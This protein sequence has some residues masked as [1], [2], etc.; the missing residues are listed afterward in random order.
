MN[1]WVVSCIDSV[2]EKP[3]VKTF[4]NEKDA[5]DYYNV[6]SG[7]H[8]RIAM[9]LVSTQ[10]LNRCEFIKKDRSICIHVPFAKK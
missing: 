2:D 3:I 9:D 6:I 4:N 8:W 1:I 10:Q 7:T 5:N